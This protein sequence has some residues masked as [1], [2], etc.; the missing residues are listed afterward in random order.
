MQA[1]QLA[2]HTKK[3]RSELYTLA[4]IEYLAR[5]TPEKITEAMNAIADRLD[6]KKDDFT[7]RAANKIL[8]QSE[9]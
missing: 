5:H 9:W 1:E 2:R 6:S 3:S 4:L 7:A 8:E